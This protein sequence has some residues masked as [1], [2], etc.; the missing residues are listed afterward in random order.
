M[1]AHHFALRALALLLILSQ[2]SVLRAQEASSDDAAQTESADVSA[3]GA[4]AGADAEVVAESEE[5]PA[6]PS[7][8]QIAQAR[9]AYAAAEAALAEGDHEMAVLRFQQAYELVPNPVVLIALG[10]ALEESGDIPRAYT[11]YRQYLRERPDAPDRTDVELKIAELAELPASVRVAVQPEGASVLVDGE[12]TGETSPASLEVRAGVHIFTFVAEGMESA[13]LERELLPGGS[14]EIDVALEPLP[15]P[16]PPPVETEGEIEEPSEDDEGDEDADDGPSAA[17]WGMTAVSAAGLISGSVLGFLALS[18]ESEFTDEP[19]EATAEAGENFALFADVSFGVAAVGAI[20]AI[21]LHALRDDD[22]EEEEPVP[23][24][25]PAE[26]SDG[27]PAEP[28]PTPAA[29]AELEVEPIFG[30]NFG[31]VRAELRF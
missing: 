13:E 29:S 30:P 4:E 25:S 2:S 28:S 31:G 17:V 19:T 18:K 5:P 16:D 26:S 1:K 10:H 3:S 20:T 6:P 9:A 23:S 21:V 7:E 22:E 8:E 12:D 27:A 15:E 14:E 11:T 24:P